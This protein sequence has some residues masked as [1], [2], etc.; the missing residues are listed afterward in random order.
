MR[1][2]KCKSV[3]CGSDVP[4]IAGLAA[5]DFS[6]LD[7]AIVKL[8]STDDR[9]SAPARQMGRLFGE[10]IA[11]ERS[12]NSQCLDE[13]FPTLLVAC[14]LGD[15]THSRVLQKSPTGA[16]LQIMG[17]ADILGWQVPRVN[18]AVCCFDTGLFEGFLSSATG[19][20]IRV[21]ETACLGM[22]DTSCEFRITF[23]SAQAAGGSREGVAFRNGNG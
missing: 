7:Q 9:F 19:E 13:A 2:H 18:R 20:A 23:H 15:S 22:G 3:C 6:A 11:L 10:R 4:A 14:G 1:S 17:C 5:H 21:E 8:I 16:L 12:V